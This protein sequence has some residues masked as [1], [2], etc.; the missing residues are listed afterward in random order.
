MDVAKEVV[1]HAS[2]GFLI[3]FACTDCPSHVLMVAHICQYQTLKQSTK[4][5]VSKQ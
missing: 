1:V 4:F 5:K 2:I 3:C